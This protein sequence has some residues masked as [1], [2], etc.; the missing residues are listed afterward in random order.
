MECGFARGAV[1]GFTLIEVM[2]AMVITTFI[3]TLAYSGLSTAITAAERHELQAQQIAA[4][5]LPL[6]IIERDIR[7]IVNRGIVDE[8]GD[9]IAAL[10]GGS[11]DDYPLLLT[12]MGW[13]NPRQLARGE[14]Q[15]VRYRL[16]DN[17][18]WRES[19]PVLDRLNLEAGQQDSKLLAGVLRFELAFLDPTA[20]GAGQSLLGGQ[21]SE[22]WQAKD[23]LPLALELLL[24]IEGFGE[25]RRVFAIP[26]Q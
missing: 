14:L 26:A 16:E 3:A 8:Y 2:L 13:S 24:E 18:L 21:W 5:Q 17:Q 1:G 7:H 25:V 22:Q 15:R 10:A 20:S 9:E 23:R 19:W 12:R 4:I 6:T 11:F